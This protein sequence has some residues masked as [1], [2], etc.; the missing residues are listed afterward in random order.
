VAW[1]LLIAAWHKLF[2]VTVPY[3]VQDILAVA[4]KMSDEPVEIAKTIYFLSEGKT[5]YVSRIAEYMRLSEY[6]AHF[7]RAGWPTTIKRKRK[8][9]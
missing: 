7:E 2:G 3:H 6:R 1:I 8:S 5:D 9:A 4:D